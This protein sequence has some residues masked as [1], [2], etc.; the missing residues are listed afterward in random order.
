MNFRKIRAARRLCLTVQMA[1]S[2]LQAPLEM[3]IYSS[4]Q[5]F[6]LSLDIHKKVWV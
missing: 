1:C 6:S 5:Y 3:G 2:L 4:L